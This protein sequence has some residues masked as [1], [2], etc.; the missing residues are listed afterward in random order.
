MVVVQ[1]SRHPD[2]YPMVTIRPDTGFP[3]F[4]FF[5]TC[6]YFESEG[7]VVFAIFTRINNREFY[8]LILAQLKKPITTDS[9]RRHR[10]HRHHPL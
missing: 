10:P 4:L 1:E 8:F 5:S 7:E 3:C 6:T 2:I 9:I